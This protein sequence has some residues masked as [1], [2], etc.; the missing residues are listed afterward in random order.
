MDNVEVSSP[1]YPLLPYLRQNLRDKFCI[2]YELLETNL[3]AK[4][5]VKSVG[6]GLRGGI[7]Q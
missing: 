3:F 4:M 1:C 6:I 7:E 2:V 5:L